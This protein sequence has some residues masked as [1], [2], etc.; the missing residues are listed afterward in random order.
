ML[1]SISSQLTKCTLNRGTCCG[2]PAALSVSHEQWR[3]GLDDLL[4]DSFAPRFARLERRNAGA[5]VLG[6]PADIRTKN[7]WTLAELSGHSS[8]DRLQ[9]LLSRAKWDG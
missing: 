5:M 2:G 9:H 1:Q 8:P 6:L 7:C 4:L 3:A